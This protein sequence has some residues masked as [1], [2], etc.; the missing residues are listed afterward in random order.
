M[1]AFCSFVR[2]ARPG[3]RLIAS[4]AC[5]IGGP[6]SNMARSDGTSVVQVR[7]RSRTTRTEVQAL[8][9]YLVSEKAANSNNRVFV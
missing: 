6:V 4:T 5:S 2:G 3:I 9:Q 8:T 7:S 1:A